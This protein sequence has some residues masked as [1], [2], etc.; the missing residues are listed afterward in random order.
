[1]RCLKKI[2][3]GPIQIITLGFAFIILNGAILLSLPIASKDFHSI[4]FVDALF[5]S[6]S[7]TFVT[8]LVVYDTYTQFSLFGQLVIICL[9][10]VGGLGFI[11]VAD[12]F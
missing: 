8:G 7:A 1:M 2:K 4:P 6:T 11:V 3:F 10:Q 9:I 12:L 5:T